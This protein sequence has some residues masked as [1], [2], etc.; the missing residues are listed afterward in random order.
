[1]TARRLCEIYKSLKHREMYLYVDR[2]EGLERVPEELLDQVGKTARVTTLEL[3]PE[4]K[5]VRAR[6][7]EVLAAIEEKGYYLQLPPAKEQRLEME[8]RMR[9]L[10]ARNEKLQ[11]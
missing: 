8:A 3:T 4:R 7:A 5:L 6:A 9:E 10:A 11:R 2:D 1:M